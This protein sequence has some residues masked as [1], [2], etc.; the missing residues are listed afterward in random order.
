MIYEPDYYACADAL[1]ESLHHRI[2]NSELNLEGA[3][4]FL[5]HLFCIELLFE[6]RVSYQ[7]LPSVS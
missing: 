1:F 5:L 4:I 2:H 3:A 6:G 7:G